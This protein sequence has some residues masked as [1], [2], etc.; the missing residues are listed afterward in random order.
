MA[1]TFEEKHHGNIMGIS[2]ENHWNIMGISWEMVSIMGISWEYTFF[3]IYHGK[4]VMCNI[5]QAFLADPQLFF[6][7]AVVHIGEVG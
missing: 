5:R 3:L 7:E 2:W 1:G 4:S 6:W